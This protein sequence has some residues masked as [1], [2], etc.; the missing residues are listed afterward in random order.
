MCDATDQDSCLG[1]CT[2][3]KFCKLP[4]DGL[5]CDYKGHLDWVCDTDDD[6]AASCEKNDFGERE[7]KIPIST[8]TL[9]A[10]KYGAA[11]DGN[12]YIYIDGSNF[13]P[14]ASKWGA[15]FLDKVTYG[16]AANPGYYEARECVVVKAST[17]IRCKTAPSIGSKLYW[18]AVIKGQS[19]PVHTDTSPTTYFAL[20]NIAS[21]ETEGSSQVYDRVNLETEFIDGK[22]FTDN[23][24]SCPPFKSSTAT[25]LCGCRCIDPDE[26]CNVV[27]WADSK[28]GNSDNMF[29]SEGEL[30]YPETTEAF[31]CMPS[32]GLGLSNELVTHGPTSGTYY[33]DDSVL[34]DY[35]LTIK[36][37]NFGY[38][39]AK[40]PIFQADIQIVFDKRA[41]TVSSIYNDLLTRDPLAPIND[42]IDVIYRFPLPIGFGF[43]DKTLQVETHTANPSSGGPPVS[44]N[45][46]RFVYNPPVIDN[47]HV[48]PWG[49]TN[50]DVDFYRLTL[51]GFNFGSGDCN[52]RTFHVVPAPS[53]NY[54]N[55]KP[56]Q[57]TNQRPTDETECRFMNPAPFLGSARVNDTSHYKQI[58]QF[59][60]YRVGEYVAPTAGNVTI[61]VGNR[62]ETRGFANKSPSLQA[63]FLS[64]VAPMRYDNA[65][66]S[67][68]GTKQDSIAAL[69]DANPESNK[70]YQNP[71]IGPAT[72][73]VGDALVHLPNQSPW[74][75]GPFPTK[76]QRLGLALPG[77]ELGIDL[78]R[79]RVMVE[80]V[81]G[82]ILGGT[83]CNLEGKGPYFRGTKECKR[84]DGVSN[85]DFLQCQAKRKLPP[86]APKE[87]I[88]DA[89]DVSRAWC[90]ANPKGLRAG[91][92]IN[93]EG[94][95]EPNE[96]G[97][98]INGRPGMVPEGREP[99]EKIEDRSLDHLLNTGFM[100]LSKCGANNLCEANLQQTCKFDSECD[101][102]FK[103]IF[104]SIPPGQGRNKNLLV[105][106]DSKRS[107]RNSNIKI[108][109]LPPVL[110]YT[111]N[112]KM[113]SNR[114]VDM[115]GNTLCTSVQN[116][117]S[118]GTVGTN[119]QTSDSEECRKVPTR[120]LDVQIRGDNFGLYGEILF[121]D[122]RINQCTNVT[123]GCCNGDM[124][125]D[126]ISDS[127]YLLTKSECL[128]KERDSYLQPYIWVN[129]QGHACKDNIDL[130]CHCRARQSCS[131]AAAWNDNIR[132]FENDILISNSKSCTNLGGA[133]YTRSCLC[134]L[135]KGYARDSKNGM[136]ERCP[137]TT[138]SLVDG[139]KEEGYV[140][141]NGRCVQNDVERTAGKAVENVERIWDHDSVVFQLPSGIGIGH[142]IEISVTSQTTSSNLFDYEPPKIVKVEYDD[143]F[144]L[145]N[146]VHYPTELS[147]GPTAGTTDKDYVTLIGTNFGNHD[148]EVHMGFG[149]TECE[150]LL[151]AQGQGQ[152]PDVCLFR[153]NIISQDHDEIVF[154]L[155]PGIG[156]KI[157]IRVRVGGQVSNM[158]VTFDYHVPEIAAIYPL[159][160][161][162]DGYALQPEYSG[163]VTPFQEI[164]IVGV[165]FGTVYARVRVLN[166]G[167]HVYTGYPVKSNNTCLTFY[168][169]QGT[170]LNHTVLLEVGN[171]TSIVKQQVKPIQTSGRPVVNYEFNYNTP[172][173]YPIMTMGDLNRDA[174]KP[175]WT[176]MDGNKN[177]PATNGNYYAP[178]TGCANP[179]TQMAPTVDPENPPKK[180]KC[181]S[182]AIVYIYGENFGCCVH[183]M[184][185]IEANNGVFE[186]DCRGKQEDLTRGP[187]CSETLPPRLV[188]T[189]ENGLIKYLNVRTYDHYQI[190]VELPAGTGRSTISMEVGPDFSA[191]RQTNTKWPLGT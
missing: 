5:D 125:R 110:T 188:L 112:N 118:P 182:P 135:N 107:E 81:D 75:C 87:L 23:S 170:G 25:R 57:C 40:P 2:A 73:G 128:A 35:Y 76:G 22:I 34:A 42:P 49:T 80:K 115:E 103:I 119:D 189:D 190:S 31:N 3:E 60:I 15:T 21:I 101:S 169:P 90:D 74:V 27:F 145:I 175:F 98:W 142:H 151:N 17:Q 147:V 65:P 95:L 174:D 7:C 79:I 141:L 121:H 137:I 1:T 93:E 104:I 152:G 106:R 36:G 41:Y 33:N 172:I 191:N 131:I 111:I 32:A 6:C 29:L 51:E 38:K 50:D 12:E 86:T 134:S 123:F 59:K 58:I 153:C 66:G 97:E 165:H 10:S 43:Q 83:R 69:F 177:F 70:C 149:S 18:V 157:P 26:E 144:K 158:D 179:E 56:F 129:T 156:S 171:Q 184:E 92:V 61:C 102:M 68:I 55:P 20:P 108:N 14:L 114:V 124:D 161:R 100:I 9:P 166:I 85:D 176:V 96:N 120:G 180:R 62:C 88:A 122:G 94:D 64:T 164:T 11:P 140:N 163:A 139:D 132:A 63:D 127:I 46:V 8:D 105:E 89:N 155:P 181:I 45:I 13:G 67:F 28:Q 48:A 168:L 109:Y 30:P 116:G 185:E 84:G 130:N 71:R 154:V 4:Y 16:P 162:T 167:I 24:L 37:R 39:L 54:P 19:S 150:G 160:G 126:T 44:S 148:A 91:F 117:Y 183:T 82:A 138:T 136:C 72:T 77:L 133:T 143:K 53:R 52:C 99:S 159:N 187:I 178:T 78:S 173:V 47:I 146:K 113:Y 186:N